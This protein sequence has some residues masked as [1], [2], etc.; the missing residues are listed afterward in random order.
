MTATTIS[1]RGETLSFPD[2]FVWGA[3]TAAYQVEGATREGGRGV[4][5]WD[6]FSRTPGR[7][8]GGHTGDVACDHYHRH[9]D[10]VRM[11]AELGLGAYRFSVAWPRVQPSGSGPVN[12]AGLDF[13]DRLVNELL[14]ADITPYV[15]LYHWD[16]PQEL[17]DRGGWTD[18][19]TAHRFADYARAVHDR[20]G[21]RVGTWMTINEPWVAAFL[22]YGIGAHAPGRASAAEAFRA[23]HHLLLA[24]GLGA[25]VLR[26]AGAREIALTLNLA[27]V[28][29]PGQVSDPDLVPS[30]ADAEA[31]NRVDCLLNR[32]FLDP[33]LR[34]EYPEPVLAIVDRI[35]GLGHV[36]DGDLETINQP[37]DLLGINYYTP[38]VVRSEPGEPANAA[39]PGTE[40]VMF[41]GAHAPTTAMGW[42]IVPTG[43]SRLLVRLSRDFPEVGLIVTENGAAFDDVVTGDRVHDTDRTAFFDNHLRAA[44]E[45]IEAGVDLRGFLAW[46]LMDNFEWAEGYHKRFGIVHVDFETQRRLPKD[47]ALWYREV[48]RRNGLR[49]ERARRP[50]LEAVAARAGVSRSTVSRVINGES[51]VSDE[52]REIVMKAV[53]E[54][55]YVPNSAARSLVTRRTDTVALVVSDV[56]D[57]SHAGDS[58][59]SATVRSTV[60][61]LEEAGKHVTLMLAD[62]PRSRQRVE[63]YVTSGHVDGVVL[64]SAHGADT[65]PGALAGT[66]VPAVLLGRPAVA[67]R[68]PYVDV[69]NAGGAAAAV[70][71]LLDRGRSRIAAI[72]GPPDVTAAQERLRGYRETLREAGHRL[73][74]AVGDLTHAS[75]AEAMRRLLRDDPG[76]DAVFAAGDLMALGALRVLHESGRRVPDD[77]AVVGFDDIEAACYAVPPLTTVRGLRA[78][79]ARAAVRLLLRHLDGGPVSSATLPTELVIRQ[80][81]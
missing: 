2:G 64:V 53:A 57:G 65:L 45:A 14:A 50:T 51:M 20:L 60:R 54:L 66:S 44:H 19:D 33:V 76:L 48:I 73:I 74:V 1:A 56:S 4:S 77:V 31:V 72:S 22:G 63:Q 39:Y 71:H 61:E 11:M 7:V 9:A 10:D 3:A 78:E 52:F 67:T 81:T 32:Q 21:D 24:H 59:F 37:I 29:T 41:S 47:S 36:L 34:G 42:P 70:R 79:Q 69:D 26:D 30:A 12:A 38:C 58:L 43:L 62:T 35:A 40:D 6:T 68:T 28:M 55:G 25:R 80:S 27:P 5:I 8:A 46:S 13:Y 75:G 16:L 18:R 15:T 49:R 23:S 17:E